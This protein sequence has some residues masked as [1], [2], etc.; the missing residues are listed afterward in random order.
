MRCGREVPVAACYSRPGMAETSAKQAFEMRNRFDMARP[1]TTL[2]LRIL[3]K[4]YVVNRE[5]YAAYIIHT[6]WLR[7]SA[8]TRP[9]VTTSR[10][11][12]VLYGRVPQRRARP[13]Y[14][15]PART[16]QEPKPRLMFGSCQAHVRHKGPHLE[17]GFLRLALLAACGLGRR[18]SEV[19]KLSKAPS[20]P[21]VRV[22]V[23]VRVRGTG[24]GRGRVRV[25]VRGRG[26]ARV[27]GRGRD[28]PRV[29]V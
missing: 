17:R 27:R 3:T 14:A 24:R 7:L 29:S 4:P 6:N 13:P 16:C 12:R 15:P 10:F 23:R 20:G 22:R 26:R 11:V 19:A 18:A 25:R 2:Y 28:R 1:Y 8:R 9:R 21:E 5:N